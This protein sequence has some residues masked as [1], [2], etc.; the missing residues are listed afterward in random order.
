[1]AGYSGDDVDGDA[2]IVSC[3]LQRSTHVALGPEAEGASRMVPCG[4]R[5]AKDPS[6]ARLRTRHGQIA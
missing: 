2:E 1:M 5:L 6:S 4:K 3:Y